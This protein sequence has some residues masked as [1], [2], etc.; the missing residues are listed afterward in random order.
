MIYVTGP[1]Y[2]PGHKHFCQ[3]AL[4]HY[5]TSCI[6]LK[7]VFLFCFG[8]K[9]DHNWVNV[10]VCTL[11][12]VYS[13]FI[14][15]WLKIKNTSTKINLLSA[16][17]SSKN[18]PWSLR[19]ILINCGE[20]ND[21]DKIPPPQNV[22]ISASLSLVLQRFM[23]ITIDDLVCKHCKCLVIAVQLLCMSTWS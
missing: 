10:Q 18:E 14:F 12:F 2:Q 8:V 6:F 23:Q 11:Y 19:Y 7:N 5:C 3:T 20:K 21:S 16:H 13:V 22:I 15:I 17:N 9:G 1:H 4:R